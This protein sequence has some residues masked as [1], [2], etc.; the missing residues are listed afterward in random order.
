MG[1]GYFPEH[2]SISRRE[3]WGRNRPY[4]KRASYNEILSVRRSYGI[5]VAKVAKNS[6]PRAS[7]VSKP[8]YL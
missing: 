7:M 2:V 5:F 6:M 8:E 1:A 4:S 3:P